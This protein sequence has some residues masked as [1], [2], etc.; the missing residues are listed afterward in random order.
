MNT[1]AIRDELS[2][3][4][5]SNF[6]AQDMEIL[7]ELSEIFV[8]S[9]SC[10]LLNSEEQPMDGAIP[11]SRYLNL[12]TLREFMNAKSKR[13]LTFNI[14]MEGVHS[15]VIASA[16]QGKPGGNPC[17]ITFKNLEGFLQA[18]LCLRGPKRKMVSLFSAKCTAMVVR[19]HIALQKDLAKTRA[20]LAEEKAQVQRRVF[21]IVKEAV[22]E[23]RR[24]NGLRYTDCVW[25]LK[26]FTQC[27]KRLK[28]LTYYQGDT[29]YVRAQFLRNAHDAMKFF[30]GLSQRNPVADQPKY[31]QMKISDNFV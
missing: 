22:K 15:S 31:T 17:Q 30:Y 19:L 20:E 14:I 26:N 27:C 9:Y 23:W 5:Y 11:S 3:F 2:E 6:D 18:C 13:A 28:L 29:P 7:N 4:I 1:Q 16:V 24:E 21:L 8:K 25:R 10:L 12:D